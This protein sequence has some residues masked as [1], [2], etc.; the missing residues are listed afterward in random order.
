M[1]VQQKQQG[2]FSIY[3]AQP[4]IITRA[5]FYCLL[6]FVIRLFALP[7]LFRYSSN[8]INGSMRIHFFAESHTKIF[9]IDAQH[10][11]S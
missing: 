11:T 1:T 3:G 10:P 6:F 4:K 5:L 8:L 2:L 9:P 7:S